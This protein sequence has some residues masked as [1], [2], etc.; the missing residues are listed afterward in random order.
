M[1][2][3]TFRV[4]QWTHQRLESL[5]SSL[6]HHLYREC[7]SSSKTSLN[8]TLSS[9]Q[10]APLKWYHHFVKR[11]QFPV[12]LHQYLPTTLRAATEWLLLLLKNW[13]RAMLNCRKLTG[14]WIY[15]VKSQSKVRNNGLMCQKSKSI[16]Y[17]KE[18]NNFLIVIAVTM[19]WLTDM[20]G[21]ARINHFSGKQSVL[22]LYLFWWSHNISTPNQCYWDFKRFTST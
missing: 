19:S 5:D 18:S 22:K 2:F 10:K 4:S 1:V 3:I 11:R 21:I 20:W 12:I 8:Q 6:S 17:Y 16:S 15:A 9:T 13:H 7:L 14:K